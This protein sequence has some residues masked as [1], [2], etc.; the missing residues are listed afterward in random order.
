[1]SRSQIPGERVRSLTDQLLAVP[2]S[3]YQQRSLQAALFLFLD[4]RTKTALHRAGLVSKSALSRCLGQN[5]TRMGPARLLNPYDWDTTAC[6]T[7]LE[8]A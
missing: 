4:T 5:G 8:T 6:W 3:P 7:L 2:T 1:M